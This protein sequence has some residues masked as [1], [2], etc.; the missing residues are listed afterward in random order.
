MSDH[1]VLP[2]ELAGECGA[3]MECTRDEKAT[4]GATDVVLTELTIKTNFD[5]KL[6]RLVDNMSTN[7]KETLPA[8]I[9]VTNALDKMI[10]LLYALCSAQAL[11]AF[12]LTCLHEQLLSHC[13]NLE[14][15][16]VLCDH[17][18]HVLT[19]WPR[20]FGDHV[21]QF[22]TRWNA[23]ESCVNMLFGDFD[24]NSVR[25]FTGSGLFYWSYMVIVCLIL[26]NMMLAIVMSAYKDVSKEGYQG[27]SSKLLAR[28]IEDGKPAVG[29]IV[30][31]L[32]RENV[33]VD[34]KIQILLLLPILQA[35]LKNER[36]DSGAI[37]TKA[38]VTPTF[39]RE[40]FPS[41]DISDNEIGATFRF[42]GEEPPV[43]EC[44]LTIT[45]PPGAQETSENSNEPVIAP[46]PANP[47]RR[48][49]GVPL[50]IR[51]EVVITVRQVSKTKLLKK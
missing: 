7:P 43:D 10:T 31:K 39:L 42:L 48:V 13:V 28:R 9:A 18:C 16:S 44:S 49:V 33:I 27:E 24:Y 25:Q 50:W 12:H 1:S 45:D 36:L 32:T 22:S 8:L 4:L 19:H 17:F 15:F 5:D 3:S 29:T 34:G 30:P 41:V 14:T 46:A 38:M 23:M 51:G 40:L 21:R 35:K 20:S 6:H 26:L 2:S 47:I 37:Q 11:C